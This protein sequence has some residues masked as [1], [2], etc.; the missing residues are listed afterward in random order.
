MHQRP[1]HVQKGRRMCICCS[2]C[3]LPSPG[4]L[5]SALLL[6]RTSAGCSHCA[7][8]EPCPP[9]Q[10]WFFLGLCPH[11]IPQPRSC[12]VPAGWSLFW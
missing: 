5:N 2:L 3:S 7:R 1:G 10:A 9:H 4:G 8:P 6:L 12:W 11:L